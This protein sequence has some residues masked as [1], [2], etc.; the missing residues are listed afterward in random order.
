MKGSSTCQPRMTSTARST[1]V[2]SRLSHGA[3]TKSSITLPSDQARGVGE[4]HGQGEQGAHDQAEIASQAQ[5]GR[6]QLGADTAMLIQPEHSEAD[7]EQ[8]ESALPTEQDASRPQEC[9]HN[10]ARDAYRAPGHA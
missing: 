10:G 7:D 6:R 5:I 3:E 8:R 1:T 4:N 9:R 2:M